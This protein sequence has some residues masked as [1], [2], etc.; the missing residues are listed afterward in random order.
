MRKSPAI[1]ALVALAIRSGPQGGRGADRG[2]PTRPPTRPGQAHQSAQAVQFVDV[3]Y[4][5]SEKARRPNRL[6]DSADRDQ[7]QGPRR[8]RGRGRQRRARRSTRQRSRR[9][10]SSYSKPAEIDKKPAPVKIT[11]KYDFV[12]TEEPA[13]AV[14][15]YEGIIRDRCYQEVDP[16]A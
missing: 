15:N 7:R 12:F 10:R 9:S 4:P 13:G 1:A 3:P 8:R 6:R 11:Y 16:R 2:L 14:V 5:E